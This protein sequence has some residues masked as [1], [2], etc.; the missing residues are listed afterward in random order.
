[1]DVGLRPVGW[2]L[3]LAALALGLDFVPLFDLLGYDFAFGNVT[4]S[5]EPDASAASGWRVNGWVKK[6]LL[7][8]FRMG[9][10]VDMS[11]V[12]VESPRVQPRQA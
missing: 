7:L 9:A 8:G 1:M 11:V 10:V 2:A 6:G 3:V 5:G 4:V 12:S